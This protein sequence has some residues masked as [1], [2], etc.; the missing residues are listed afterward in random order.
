M[1]EKDVM[2]PRRPDVTVTRFSCNMVTMSFDLKEPLFITILIFHGY[3]PGNSIMS[4]IAWL[5]S[6]KIRQPHSIPP[7]CLVFNSPRLLPQLRWLDLS[8]NLGK[9]VAISRAWCGF[10]EET[11]LF[12]VYKHPSERHLQGRSCIFCPGGP[13]STG[14]HLHLSLFMRCFFHGTPKLCQ[15]QADPIWMYDWRILEDHDTDW[16][17][18]P[19]APST[20]WHVLTPLAMPG[21]PMV[22][23]WLWSQSPFRTTRRWSWSVSDRRGYRNGLRDVAIAPLTAS[24]LFCPLL[25]RLAPWQRRVAERLRWSLKWS[26]LKGKRQIRIV[27]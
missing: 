15:Y 18:N 24:L 7:S 26:W 16:E 19:G 12:L 11:A 27:E 20:F 14:H 4:K 1:R 21:S 22:V 9:I 10:K 8:M 25:I 5:G 3:L 2:A 23:P 6:E 17:K 13:N